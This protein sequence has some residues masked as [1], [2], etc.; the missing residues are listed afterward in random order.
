MLPIVPACGALVHFLYGNGSHSNHVTVTPDWA[1]AF[2]P[3]CVSA[4]HR[5][6]P[7]VLGR[8]GSSVVYRVVSVNRSD[9]LIYALK[10]VR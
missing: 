6:H 3:V 5:A 7:Q 1:M 9:K 4:P 2:Q 10:V 8:G